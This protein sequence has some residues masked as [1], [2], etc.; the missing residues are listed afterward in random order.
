MSTFYALDENKKP[1]PISI[2]DLAEVYGDTN[3]RVTKQDTIGDVMISTV[4]L[5]I[6]HR[7][8]GEGDPV[9]WETMIFGGKHDGYQ[10]RYTSHEEALKGH[11]R[12]INL[13]L[14]DDEK[15]IEKIDVKIDKL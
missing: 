1:F 14:G 2:E 6:D 15:K 4:F 10:E 3:S 5:V 9:L 12:S 7:F 13:V 11:E 8:S